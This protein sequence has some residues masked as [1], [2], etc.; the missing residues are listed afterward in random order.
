MVIPSNITTNPPGFLK[1]LHKT[2]EMPDDENSRA[3]LLAFRCGMLEGTIK[4]AGFDSKLLRWFWRLYLR[5][6]PEYLVPIA[7]LLKEF[8]RD[9][10]VFYWEFCPN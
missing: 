2:F 1:R 3:L 10:N 6:H 8:A 4:I 5:M 7:R 9:P